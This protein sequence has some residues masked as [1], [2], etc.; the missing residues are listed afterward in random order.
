MKVIKVSMKKYRNEMRGET[1]APRENP[2]SSDI[3]RHD[4]HMRKSGSEPGRGLNPVGLGGRAAV[5]QSVHR[6]LSTEVRG[7][8]AA[9]GGVSLDQ[10]ERK[11]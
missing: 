9:I 10:Q 11:S 1:G 8:Q 6:L 4:S 2:P 3:A 7:H 5:G